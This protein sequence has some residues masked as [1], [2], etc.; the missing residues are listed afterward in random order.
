[1]FTRDQIEE[2]KKKLIMLGTKDT[3]FPDAHKLNGE[4]IIA[5][6]QDGENKKIPLSSIINDDFINVSKDTTEILTLSTAVSKIDINNRKLGQVITFKDSANSWAIRQF[7]GSSLD[8]WNDISLW[9]SIS[10]IDELKSQVETNTSNISSINTEVSTLQSKVGTISSVKEATSGIAYTNTINIDLKQGDM[11]DVYW[12]GDNIASN[13]TLLDSSKATLAT[14]KN[15]VKQTV[16]I[17]NPTTYLSLVKKGSLVTDGVATFHIEGGLVKD[18]NN[19]NEKVTS[20][21]I[22]IDNIKKENIITLDKWVSGYFANKKTGANSKANGL[23][24]VTDFVVIPLGVTSVSVRTAIQGN[25]GICFYDKEQTFIS[26]VSGND[27]ALTDR[28]VEVPSNAVYLKISLLL[29]AGSRDDVKLSVIGFATILQN[30]SQETRK[31]S[32]AVLADDGVEINPNRNVGWIDA[33]GNKQSTPT[34]YF[35]TDVIELSKGQGISVTSADPSGTVIARISTWDSTGN[36]F[37]KV[38]AFGT[39]TETTARYVAIEDKEYIIVSGYSPNS[40]T[41]MFL[42]NAIPGILTNNESSIKSIVKDSINEFEEFDFLPFQTIGIIGDS[43]A[44]GCSNYY[45]DSAGK[46]V[47][48]DRPAF[49][50]GAFLGRE[51]GIDVKLFAKGG[52]ST[53][54]W[55][56]SDWGLAKAQ[57]SGNKCECYI[58]G[59]GVNDYSKSGLDYVGT[60]AD[61]HV[62]NESANADSFYGNY[63]R[64]IAALKAIQPRCKIFMFNLPNTPNN[65]I[66]ATT[67]AYRNAIK[68]IYTLYDNVYLLDLFEDKWYESKEIN[69]TYY[70]AHYTAIGYKAMAMHIKKI[71]NKFIKDNIDYDVLLQCHPTEKMDIN[72]LVELMVETIA[73][74][75]PVIRINK[76]DFPYDVVR[77]RLA[78]IDFHTMEYV[79]ECLRN[80]TTKVRNIR[81]YMLTTLYNAPVT[82]SNY[83]KAEVNHDFYGK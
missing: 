29:S 31:A 65:K 64:I 59:L 75:Q 67:T 40:M 23:F 9:K 37:Y 24:D 19:I 78:K 52:A 16:T 11:V 18:V 44:S 25:A 13:L 71:L 54:T 4:E 57:Q 36:T 5:I 58:I 38:C 63:S 21:Q 22:E 32:N 48:L 34:T 62:G 20:H 28:I 3:Q 7:T 53:K 39:T 77:S 50:W 14:L 47:G 74:K 15:G 80:N 61:V 2:I 70:G 35:Y 69:A 42:E 56:S 17:Q 8:N 81:S 72:E 46:M 83:Y 45:D 82:C 33:N 41:I 76:Y 27:V 49:S 79:L 26:A 51:T 60:A 30:I 10:G 68:E 6:V 43:L 12:D 73:V 55:L 1:M 66:N